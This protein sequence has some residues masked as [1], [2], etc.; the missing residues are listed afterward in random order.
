MVIIQLKIV[1]QK[2][3]KLLKNIEVF[4]FLSIWDTACPT[5][6]FWKDWLLSA[7]IMMVGDERLELPTSS[8]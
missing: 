4:A 2:L 7:Q 6:L 5:A 8:V 3:L 1:I